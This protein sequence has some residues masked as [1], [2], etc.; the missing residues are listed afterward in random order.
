MN[1]KSLSVKGLSKVDENSSIEEK[2]SKL[3][4]LLKEHLN[5]S[6][7]DMAE[8]LKLSVK[9]NASELSEQFINIAPL[10]DYSLL[11]DDKVKM[12]EFLANEACEAKYWAYHSMA[13]DKNESTR[14]IFRNDAV[15]DGTTFR[16]Y[17]IVNS[18][19]RILHAFSQAEE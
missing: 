7:E 17:V 8:A 19:G 14:F 10:G 1:K 18:A 9:A 16:G 5:I 6:L 11:M 15:D 12:A 4:S 2:L 3:N 13:N